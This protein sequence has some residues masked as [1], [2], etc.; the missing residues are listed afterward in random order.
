MNR[1]LL[2]GAVGVVASVAQAGPVLVYQNDF[3]SRSSYGAEWITSPEWNTAENFGGFLGRFGQETHILQWDAYRPDG[4]GGNGGD[5]DGGGD[6]G[7]G[8]GGGGGDEPGG[9]GGGAGGHPGGRSMVDYTLVFDLYLLDS[10]DGSYAGPY[11]PD[12]FGV[13][14]NGES[15]LW[16]GWH[17]TKPELNVATPN[18]G[19]VNLGFNAAYKDSIYRNLTLSFSAPLDLEQISVHFIGAPSSVNLDDE[20]WGIDNVRLYAEAVPAPSGI[21]LGGLG[22]GLASRRRRG[23]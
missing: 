5:S 11:G 2:L 15:L 6:G 9:D 3:S 13:S 10:W 8:G 16:A 7:D 18:V 17:S 21:A 23:A 1:L 19:P 20:S 12:H 14:V 4:G 22:L